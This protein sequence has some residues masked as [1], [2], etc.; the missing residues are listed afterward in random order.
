MAEDVYHPIDEFVANG[1]HSSR[2]ITSSHNRPLIGK[3]EAITV[4]DV[5]L[6]ARFAALPPVT[7]LVDYADD[8]AAAAGGVPVAGYYRTGSVVKIRVV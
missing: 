2:V 4:S 8:A 5:A 1:D 3:G 7:G 6:S